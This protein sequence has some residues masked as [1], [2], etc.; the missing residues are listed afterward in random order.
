M[1]CCEIDGIY[2]PK[3]REFHPSLYWHEKYNEYLMP[4]QCYERYRAARARFG[5]ET[6]DEECQAD[7]QL[8]LKLKKINYMENKGTCVICSTIT[9]FAG[10]DRGEYICSDKCLSKMSG[11]LRIRNIS[12][13]EK[14]EECNDEC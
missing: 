11:H 2:C 1:I 13:S 12:E 8:R 4:N 5:A 9:N 14:K 10:V 6:S 7:Y 3:C